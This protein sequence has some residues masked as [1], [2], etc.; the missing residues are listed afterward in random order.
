LARGLYFARGARLQGT[1][2]GPD[3]ITWKKGSVL[4][5]P[6]FNLVVVMDDR[7]ASVTHIVLFLDHG[8]AIVRFALLDNSGAIAIAITI[9]VA[10][11]HRDASANRP[12]VHADIVRQGWRQPAL[13]QQDISSSSPP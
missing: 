1:V 2:R 11:T 9:L 12:D 8:G 5:E 6:L 3:T 4:P 10:L 7:F 13:Q